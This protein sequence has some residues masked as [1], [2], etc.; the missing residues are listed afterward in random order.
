M[1]TIVQGVWLP[2]TSKGEEFPSI[3]WI[4]M[5]C[6]VWCFRMPIPYLPTLW[7]V[8]VGWLVGYLVGLGVF[9]VVVG[10]F[11]VAVQ[12]FLLFHGIFVITQVH[13]P[14]FSLRN[15]FLLVMSSVGGCHLQNK[16][17][18][19]DISLFI[20]W[21]HDGPPTFPISPKN[22]PLLCIILTLE[23]VRIQS[24]VSWLAQE[25]YQLI[26]VQLCRW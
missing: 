10:L 20:A 25:T 22:S 8:S 5:K 9:V 12:N 13:V 26:L 15:G 24:P 17:E 19:W 4:W 1:D 11:V 14:L 21:H 7:G 23:P 18:N 2:E 6:S 3:S 16:V